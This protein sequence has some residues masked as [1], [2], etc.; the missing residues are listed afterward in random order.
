MPFGWVL[1][2]LWNRR[3]FV[4][5]WGDKLARRCSILP[6]VKSSRYSSLRHFGGVLQH[7]LRHWVDLIY[8]EEILLSN[9]G[10]IILLTGA[11]VGWFAWPL[12]QGTVGNLLIG[13]VMDKENQRQWQVRWWT[14]STSG[15]KVQEAQIG[16]FFFLKPLSNRFSRGDWAC[17]DWTIIKACSRW[18]RAAFF[19]L[20]P[21]IACLPT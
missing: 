11:L 4:S 15:V 7:L 5:E 1:D 18:V 16:D 3:V 6:G 19:I 2:E 17:Q 21:S 13:L 10:D 14:V 9:E 12:H 8:F 20:V